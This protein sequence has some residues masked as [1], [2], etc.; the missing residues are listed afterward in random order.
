MARA[1][2]TLPVG[3]DVRPDR[4]VNDDILANGGGLLIRDLSW[5]ER[6]TGRSI[7]T[8]SFDVAGL[9]AV[10]ALVIPANSDIVAHSGGG[11]VIFFLFA[12]NIR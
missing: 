11:G 8:P 10:A 5:G 1:S 4:V 2:T 6:R 12:P 9:A 3:F 7:D